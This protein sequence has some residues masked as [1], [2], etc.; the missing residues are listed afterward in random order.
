MTDP[1]RKSDSDANDEPGLAEGATPSA[2]VTDKSSAAEIGSGFPEAA[3]EAIAALLHLIKLMGGELVLNVA[4]GESERLE[5]AVRSKI[6]QY[7]SPTTN[8]ASRK[9]GLAFASHLVEQVLTQ[10]RAQAEVKRSLA[11]SSRQPAEQQRDTVAAA[12]SP[13]KFLN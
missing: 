9:A 11:K 6:E 8:P 10:L 7:T 2:V 5:R 4:G 12:T 13:S 3:T 1:V